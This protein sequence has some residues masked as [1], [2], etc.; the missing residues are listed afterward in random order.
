MAGSRP[1]AIVKFVGSNFES[2]THQSIHNVK[3]QAFIITAGTE[4]FN[5]RRVNGSGN[6]H[7]ALEK[8]Q[9]I[10]QVGGL[11]VR[12]GCSHR[13]DVETDTAVVVGSFKDPN[14]VEGAAKIDRSKGFVLVIFQAVLVIK[15]HTPKF[16]MPK[17]IGHVL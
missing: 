9:A 16:V 14:L 6:F 13:F 3:F 12:P 10:A 7:Q 4:S 11:P 5:F 15:V 8:L 17:G 1:P 2:T